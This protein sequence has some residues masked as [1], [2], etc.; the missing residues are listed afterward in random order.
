MTGWL[1]RLGLAAIITL[2]APALSP[3]P[4]ASGGLAAIV[5]DD[6]GKPIADV[7][8]SLTSPG[9]APGLHPTPAVIDQQNKEFVPQILAVPLGTSVAFPNRDN[10]RHHVYS[11]SPAKRFELPLYIGTPA[12]PV[13]F[14]KPG[15]VVLGCN[16]HD[17]MVGYVYV[18]ATP[19]F[20]KTAE[21]GKAHLADVPPGAYEARV[22]HPRMKGEPEKTGKP[23]TIAAGDPG[24]VTFV[25]AL[26]PER[27]GPQ[28]PP[29]EG[30]SQSQVHDRPAKGGPS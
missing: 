6:R 19:Y 5:Q 1:T 4:A 3:A 23:I 26:K 8:V 25:V 24:Q 9:P 30:S 29:Y 2:L 20:A 10:I 17:W 28:R 13:V 15:V 14:D 27:R 18:L 7:I 11:F 22:W 21:D 16:I 12:A